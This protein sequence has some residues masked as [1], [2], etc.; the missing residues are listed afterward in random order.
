MV[1]WRY[2]RQHH[3]TGGGGKV[4]DLT[5]NQENILKRLVTEQPRGA[6]FECSEYEKC[7]RYDLLCFGLLD[8]L[9]VNNEPRVFA[10]EEGHALIANVPSQKVVV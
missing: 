9:T 3:R 1:H 10:T 6:T 2:R 5:L 7:I 4:S 8:I